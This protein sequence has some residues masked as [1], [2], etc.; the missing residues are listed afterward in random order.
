MGLEQH[1]E[2]DSTMTN[3]AYFSTITHSTVG[4]GDI[5]PKT[6]AA[7]MVVSL[8]IIIVWIL[9]AVAQWRLLLQ[10]KKM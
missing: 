10:F 8:H 2:V 4:Y 6:S 7:K 5:S 3:A 1:F 9:V